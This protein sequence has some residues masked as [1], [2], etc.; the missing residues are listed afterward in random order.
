ML[1]PRIVDEDGV[2]HRATLKYSGTKFTL[3]GYFTTQEQSS[4]DAMFSE[5]AIIILP[6]VK[7]IEAGH[8]TSLV[9]A[10]LWTVDSV[11]FTLTKFA[12]HPDSKI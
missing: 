9:Q 10:Q 6:L 1:I 3:I 2:P 8:V 12:V 4:T 11:S 7:V 5:E